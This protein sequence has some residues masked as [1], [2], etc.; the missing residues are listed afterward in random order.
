MNPSDAYTLKEAKSW[1]RDRAA[2]GEH[3]PCC[4]QMVKVYRRKLGGSMCRSLIAFYRAGWR[5]DR[6]WTHFSSTLTNDGI[7]YRGA[8]YGKLAYWGLLLAHPDQIGF[9]R[10][11]GLGVRFIEQDALVPSHAVI[12]DGECIRLDGDPIGILASLGLRFDYNEL[13]GE[14]PI[15]GEPT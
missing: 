10:V 1:L 13:M 15:S 3:C 5:G 12:Y 2:K 7:A 9:W 6:R 8:D 4:N 11:T 14:R